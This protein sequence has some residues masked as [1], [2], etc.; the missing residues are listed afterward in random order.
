MP[1]YLN[2][3]DLSTLRLFVVA[4][5][6]GSLSAGAERLGLSLAAASKRV[7]ELESHIGTTLLQRSKRGVARHGRTGAD[8]RD[9]GG[10]RAAHTG[11]R[12]R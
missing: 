12:C 4:V 1:F 7:A 6:S 2:R 8:W 10:R 9:H 5:A 3:F 11:L